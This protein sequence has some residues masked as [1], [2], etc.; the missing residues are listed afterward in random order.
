[1]SKRMNNIDWDNYDKYMNGQ[2]AGFVCQMCD[3]IVSLDN[4][5]SSR[6]WNLICCDCAGKMAHILGMAPGTILGHVQKTGQ[7]LQ[8]DYADLTVD[9]IEELRHGT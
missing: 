2:T 3:E 7:Q 5:I 4:S 6:G 9:Y 8:G 1:M